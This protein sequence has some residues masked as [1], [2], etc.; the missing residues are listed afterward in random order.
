MR[1][2]FPKW[3]PWLYEW[4]DEGRIMR[5]SH[6]PV[7]AS[8]ARFQILTVLWPLHYIARAML[9]CDYKWNAY[10]I[11]PSIIDDEIRTAIAWKKARKAS[12]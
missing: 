7:Y 2:W 6:G 4:V 12:K 8:Y 5:R 9:W 1:G 3:C 10:R 11:G